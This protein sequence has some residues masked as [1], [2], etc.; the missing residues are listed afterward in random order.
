MANTPV[1]YVINPTNP[2]NLSEEFIT[3]TLAKA[4]ETW[5]AS[6]SKE[7]FN[8]NITIDSSARFGVQ[9]FNN[10]VVFE[11]YADSGAIAVTSVWFS[12]KSKQIVEFDMV[13]NTNYQWG[14]VM[15]SSGA[16]MDLENIATHEFGHSVG[17]NDLYTDTCANVTMYG[18]SFYGD[19]AKRTLEQP[20]IQGLQ[21]IYGM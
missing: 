19:M 4:T 10:A 3:D 11:P 17:L 12:R 14:D 15:A 18:Y 9:N 16:V 8:D 7:L 5:D 21:K 20:D 13:F 1:N 6:T 2:D